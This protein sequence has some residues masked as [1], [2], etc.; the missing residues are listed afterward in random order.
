M[1]LTE[2][3]SG[4]GA[5]GARRSDGV[6]WALVHRSRGGYHLT[7]YTPDAQG[8]LQSA[9]WTFSNLYDL[10]VFART[11]GFVE[12]QAEADDW[13]SASGAPAE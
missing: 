3:L 12:V 11:Q 1:K 9:A 10:L 2:A 8:L 5:A 6:H 4:R 13:Q 7:R